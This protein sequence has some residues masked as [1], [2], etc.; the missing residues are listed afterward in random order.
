MARNIAIS[1]QPIGLRSRYSRYSVITTATTTSTV[2]RT[3]R[4]DRTGSTRALGVLTRA[5]SYPSQRAEQLS[6]QT[7]ATEQTGAGVGADHRA[8]LRHELRVAAV[9]LAPG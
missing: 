4:A 1:V 5:P 7:G 8:D 6:A 9:D 2:R 3:E